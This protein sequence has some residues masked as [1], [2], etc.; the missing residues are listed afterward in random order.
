M[1]KA[2]R[3]WTNNVFCF[4]SSLLRIA[5]CLQHF[6]VWTWNEVILNWTIL[7]RK[8]SVCQHEY[9]KLLCPGPSLS[10]LYKGEKTFLLWKSK[11]T[12]L[13]LSNR[14]CIFVAN[15][16]YM[17]LSLV[18]LRFIYRFEL[19][20]FTHYLTLVFDICKLASIL[21]SFMCRAAIWYMDLFLLLKQVNML[22]FNLS[23]MESETKKSQQLTMLF[24]D[25]FLLP[26]V[27]S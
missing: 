24:G 14:M 27:R 15:F 23:V 2:L 20:I 19:W 18:C 12:I 25:I 9:D 26:V 17:R 3:E 8:V 4:W 1:E 22:T 6:G 7:Y 13:E 10:T 21:Y 5:L 11:N 16:K